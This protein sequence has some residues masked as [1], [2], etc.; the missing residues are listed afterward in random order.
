MTIFLYS[1]VVCILQIWFLY[2]VYRKGVC[3]YVLVYFIYTS[4]IFLPFFF[5]YLD[6]YNYVS[7]EQIVGRSTDAKTILSIGDG[8]KPLLLGIVFSFIYFLVGESSV[9]KKIHDKDKNHPFTRFD[10][11]RTFIYPIFFSALIYTIIRYIVIPDFPLFA[12]VSGDNLRDVA[13]YYG[14]N[15]SVPWVFLPSINSQAYRIAI[16]F[17]FFFL[18][19]AKNSSQKKIRGAVYFILIFSGILMVVLN[20][21]T[22][23]RTPILYLLLWL[24]VFFFS[25][26]K[27]KIIKIFV[28]VVM[29]FSALFVITSYYSGDNSNILTN[30]MARFLIGEAIG[31]FLAIEHFGS[32]FDY[33]Y[34]DI[35]FAYAQKIL[36]QDVMTFSQEWK[37]RVG[38][39]RG[40]TSIGIV[41]EMFVSFGWW[42]V[43]LY[44]PFTMLILKL[45]KNFKK[46]RKTPYWPALSGIIVVISF[47]M[48]KGFF[49]QLFTG[50]VI[51][52][53]LIFMWQRKLFRGSY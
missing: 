44:I 6:I 48:I 37:I 30:L 42:C 16:P 29:I 32:T 7:I 49:A 40:Y 12:V 13:F 3:L 45:D 15:V 39:S 9:V 38:G 36:G 17:V 26:K 35:P 2:H 53:I 21:G 11:L 50:G 28:F 23:K 33:K 20:I 41:A 31:E 51:T 19:Y 47:M 34:F 46:Y 18:L 5:I 22:F 10:K 1:L 27:L 43:L 25:Y 4:L 8:D 14:S 52:L 24:F